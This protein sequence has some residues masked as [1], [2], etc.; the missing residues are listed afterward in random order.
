MALGLHQEQRP[1]NLTITGFRPL[2]AQRTQP[3][4]STRDGAVEVVG[5]ERLFGGAMVGRRGAAQ[6]AATSEVLG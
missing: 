4:P 5:L 1:L 3:Q 2:G 6:V